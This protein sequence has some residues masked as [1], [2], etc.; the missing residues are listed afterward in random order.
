M[1]DNQ[2]T[3]KEFEKLLEI[4]GKVRGVVFQTDAEYVR[5]KKGKKGVVAVEKELE[6]LGFP[7]NYKNIKAIS[8]YPLGL[9]VVSLLVIRNM[10]N[11]QDSDI[12]EMGNLAPKYSLIVKLLMKYFLTIDMTYKESPKY[13][14]KHYTVGRLE[15]PGYSLEKK[16]FIVRITD[17]KIHPILCVYFKGY[18]KRISQFLL[19]DA[20]NFKTQETKCQ[21]SGDPYHEIVITWE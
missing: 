16:Y 15:T 12:E 19:K 3:K 6:R 17:F 7:I 21:F 11:L 2:L 5:D 13:W 20:K 14:E 1:V 10:F 8:W 4:P 18:F 9:R